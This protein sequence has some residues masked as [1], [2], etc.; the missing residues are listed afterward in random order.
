ME[1]IKKAH[2]FYTI[3]NE[4]EMRERRERVAFE[5][6][7]SIAGF[8]A[9][10]DKNIAFRNNLYIRD[11][12][13]QLLGLEPDQWS[14]FWKQVDRF[15]CGKCS[16]IELIKKYNLLKLHN[17]LL[18][19]ETCNQMLMVLQEYYLDYF[20]SLDET[21]KALILAVFD[22]VKNAKGNLKKVTMLVDY[23]K[24]RSEYIYL[25]NNN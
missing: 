13:K 8:T 18:D 25:E 9:L 20:G 11:N 6:L 10:K 22:N 19:N 16:D 2:E 23:N 4:I 24:L 15:Y 12:L 14:E 1:N 3:L 21:T 7:P 5:H 17:E